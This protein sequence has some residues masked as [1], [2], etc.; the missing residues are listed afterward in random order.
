MF[1]EQ[2]YSDLPVN[3]YKRGYFEAK[4]PH[5]LVD[6]RTE[7]E[8]ASGRIPGAVNIPLND[9]PIRLDELQTDHPLVIVCGHGMRSIMAAE[10]LAGQG[11]T[12]LYN[13]VEGTAYWIETG[14]PVER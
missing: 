4:M 1:D 9:L 13:L 7:A 14:L 12:N 10:F 6:V 3:D 5:L 2:G 11:F 8:Y